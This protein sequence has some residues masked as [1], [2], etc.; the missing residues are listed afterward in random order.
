MN[1]KLFF[2]LCLRKAKKT[3]LIIPILMGIGF[4]SGCAEKRTSLPELPQQQ[5][6]QPTAVVGSVPK[7]GAGNGERGVFRNLPYSSLSPE[8]VLDLNVPVGNGPFPLVIIIHGGGF[9]TGDKADGAELGRV[10]LLLKEGYA[11]A[12]INY[13][14]SGDAIYPAQIH[15]VKVAVRYLRANAQKYRLD[16]DHFGAWGSSAGGTLAT[17]L[18]TTCD[19]VELEGAKLGYMEQSSCVQAVVD[20]FGLVDL[21]KMDEQFEGTSCP[22]GHNKAASAESQWVGSPIQTVPD[23]VYKTN[24][25]NYIDASDPPFF[26]QHGSDDCRV[27]PEQS[28]E[29]ADALRAVI[30]DD[31]V[32]YSEIPGAAHG[33]AKFKTEANFNL[34]INFLNTYLK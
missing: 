31:N 15:D 16:P 8:Q 28:K 13:R 4:I 33:G 29:L 30:G 19:V 1:E 11:V 7:S 2:K 23:L 25:I 12:S 24:P 14:L 26:I 9:M 10:E 6:P 20:W 5:T 27:P 18:G 21:L 3:Y 34:V 22:G 32:F 17:L